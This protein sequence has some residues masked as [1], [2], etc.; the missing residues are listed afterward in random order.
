MLPAKMCRHENTVFR[1][2]RKLQAQSR[3]VMVLEAVKILLGR[4]R[5]SPASQLILSHE[6]SLPVCSPVSAAPVAAHVSSWLTSNPNN[7][8]RQAINP[9]FRKQGLKCKMFKGIYLRGNFTRDV[10]VQMCPFCFSA[11]QKTENHSSASFA[12]TVNTK[13]RS[14]CNADTP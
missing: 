4:V 6:S 10:F 8:S 14:L 11:A 7:T 13:S 12:R 3:S 5:W 1:T 2:P 9:F